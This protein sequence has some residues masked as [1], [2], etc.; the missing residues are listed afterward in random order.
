ML[1][2]LLPV[3]HAFCGTF[4]AG[5]GDEL[6]N[7]SSQVVYARENG[8]TTL[9]LA[10]DFQGDSLDFAVVI[11][12]PAGIDEDSVRV[13]EPELVQTLEEF[14]SPRLVEYACEDLHWWSPPSPRSLGCAEYN[15]AGDMWAESAAGGEGG[16]ADD[17]VTVE[18]VFSE[19]EYL[20]T[21]ISAEE[22]DGLQSWLNENGYTLGG[23]AAD[24]LQDYIDEGTWFLTAKVLLEDP[25]SSDRPLWLS[26]IQLTYESQALSLPIRL[27]TLNSTGYQEIILYGLTAEGDGALGISNLRQVDIDTDCML[28]EDLGSWY[29]GKLDELEDAWTIEHS[30]SP[31]HC[32]PCTPG[33]TL[34]PETVVELGVRDSEYPHFSRIFVRYSADQS[35]DLQLYTSGMYD[36]TQRRYIRHDENLEAY[37]RVCDHDSIDENAGSCEEEW[38]EMD[39]QAEADWQE[40]NTAG[41]CASGSSRVA[42]AGLALLAAA[43]LRFRS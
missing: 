42:L 4:V 6:Y 32:D 41:G 40:G 1:Q 35:E 38:E 13:V 19:G 22:G 17:N 25:L 34:D 30:W 31:Y 33:G 10:N 8:L 2:L 16:A 18:A 3:A 5:P 21:L 14:S 37:Y 29:R 7:E 20:F 24:M 26:P 11:P 12:V 27:G 15:L 23:D 28:D 9:T 36:Q 39:A 43:A